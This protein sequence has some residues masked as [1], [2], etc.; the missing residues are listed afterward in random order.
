VF[1]IKFCEQKSQ[2]VIKSY[3]IGLFG[4]HLGDEKRQLSANKLVV[5]KVIL[6]GYI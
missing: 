1:G 6:I 5:S 2:N 4:N 3:V